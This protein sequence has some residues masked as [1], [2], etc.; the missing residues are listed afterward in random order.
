MKGMRRVLLVLEDY[1]ELL[2]LETL[3]KKV[4]FDVEGIRNETSVTEKMMGFTPDLVVAT[5][6]G[7]KIN[8]MRVSKKVKKKGQH[9]KLLLLF[10][11]NRI[12]QERAL[13]SFSAD[14]AVETPLNPRATIMTICEL[15]GVNP[16]PI[17]AKFEKLPIAKDTA[18]P[19][20]I[21][22]I[23]AKKGQPAG[24]SDEVSSTGADPRA[25]KYMKILKEAPSAPET[26]F[27]KSIVQKEMEENAKAPPPP[28][29]WDEIDLERKNFRQSCFSR[30]K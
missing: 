7:N 1:N 11:R 5:G 18:T 9:A 15:M 19:E 14:G 21:Q 10:P 24:A 22:I 16:Q 17:M 28:E 26:T 20:G 30:N 4:G 3:L 12:Q 8:G 25:K 29:N 6:D 2:F 13:D 23:S 27:P